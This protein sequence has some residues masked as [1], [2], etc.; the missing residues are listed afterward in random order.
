[1]FNIVQQAI[2]ADLMLPNLLI[3]LWHEDRKRALEL[4]EES[5]RRHDELVKRNR[6]E[7]ANVKTEC[8]QRPREGR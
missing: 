4:A 3:G 6:E 7:K 2:D 1:M 8:I 5:G